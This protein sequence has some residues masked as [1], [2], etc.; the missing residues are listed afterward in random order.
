MLS[1]NQLIS[2]T[3]HMS[4]A[5]AMYFILSAMWMTDAKCYWQAQLVALRYWR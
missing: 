3:G 4:R 5:C 1:S 2:I